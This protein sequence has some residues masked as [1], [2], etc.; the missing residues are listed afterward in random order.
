MKKYILQ[1]Q[2][3]LLTLL[4]FISSSLFA[5]P[6][7]S[8]QLEAEVVENGGT[9]YLDVTVSM[10]GSS[11]FDLGS[12]NLQFT[13][14]SDIALN[15]NPIQSYSL[16]GSFATPTVTEPSTNKASLNL[17][18]YIPGNGKAIVTSG[19]TEIATIRFNILNPAGLADLDWSYNGGTTETVVFMDDETTQIFVNNPGTDLVSANSVILPVE[20][21]YID[22]EWTSTYEKVA[23]VHWQT[24]S[25]SLSDVFE[26][27]R[28]SNSKDWETIG[29]VAAAGTSN[30]IKNY[31][32]IDEQ[33]LEIYS[34]ILYYR[35]RSIDL[36]GKEDLTKIV[37]LERS[38][39]VV[40]IQ[41]SPTVF[42][43]KINIFIQNKNDSDTQVQMTLSDIQG[44]ILNQF[45]IYPNENYPLQNLNELQAGIYFLIMDDGNFQRTQKLVKN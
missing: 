45:S 13:F 30:S 40:N 14:D 16:T 34:N 39:S 12:C 33:A 25:E 8:L 32:F 3:L 36:N 38:Q 1:P 22:A 29:E 44:K 41:V 37:V 24:A 27:Q 31:N 18:L 9:A 20:F 21:I 4:T 19:W 15:A 42:Q 17:V 26:I 35:I 5:Q 11:A 6:T 7:F 2:I 43:D 10:T 28:S 23:R